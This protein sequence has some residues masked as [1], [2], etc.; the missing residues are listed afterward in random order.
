MK[1][2]QIINIDFSPRKQEKLFLYN[3]YF[4][5]FLKLYKNN[6]LP[7]KIL[8]TGQSGIGKSTF[9]YHL[10]NFIL[11]E[12]QDYSY[13]LRNFTINPLNRSYRLINQNCNPN[14]YLIDHFENKNIIDVSQIRDMINYANKTS[15]NNDIKLI[16]IDNA[17]SLNLY[18]INALLKI[19]EEPTSNTFFIFI[20]NSTSNLSETLKSRC[21]EFKIFFSNLNKRIILNKLL[22][23]FNLQSDQEKI[24]KI[25]SYYD[26]P[27][28][29]LN[30]VKI[31]HEKIVNLENINL[32]NVIINLMELNLKNKNNINLN[33]LQ[34][35]IELFFCKKV[36][37]SG[38]KNN[39]FI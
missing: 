36:E 6:L 23:Y 10:I 16:L 1:K 9:A 25:E 15:Y 33:L 13:D 3:E 18:S 31:L 24:E 39:I 14:F 11:S 5:F 34:N 38:N 20:H 37:K 32:D 7:N 27:G 21:I 29:I 26:S 19:V 30:I 22:S 2:K 28:M 17:E 4:E 8:F 12:K 35:C